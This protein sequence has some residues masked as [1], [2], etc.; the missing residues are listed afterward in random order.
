MAKLLHLSPKFLICF[1]IGHSDI[2]L[3]L[4]VLAIIS[5]TRRIYV[6]HLPFEAFS[7]FV[8]NRD[9]CRLFSSEV[10]NVVYPIDT[11]NLIFLDVDE[12][13]FYVLFVP[14]GLALQLFDGAD[15]ANNVLNQ[16]MRL[17]LK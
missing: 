3:E 14:G 15:L 4:P 8:F 6:S 12:L 17:S 9:L 16:V 2:F 7:H 10:F 1:V 11:R 13:G 5:F